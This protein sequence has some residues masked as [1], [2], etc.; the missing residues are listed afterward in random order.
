MLNGDEDEYFGYDEDER[1]DSQD[2]VSAIKANKGVFTIGLAA[3]FFTCCLG[4]LGLLWY[5]KREGPKKAYRIGWLGGLIAILVILGI[6]ITVLLA[7]G[8]VHAGTYTAYILL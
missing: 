4:G 2:E 8:A 1:A 7:T 3:G 5:R 6:V